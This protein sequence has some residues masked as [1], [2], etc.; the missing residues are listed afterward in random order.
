MSQHDAEEFYGRHILTNDLQVLWTDASQ[1]ELPVMISIQELMHYSTPFD[2]LAAKLLEKCPE[3]SKEEIRGI[4]LSDELW[5]VEQ[6]SL[7]DNVVLPY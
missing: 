1:D 5:I 7:V 4:W 2:Y 6:G 3:R